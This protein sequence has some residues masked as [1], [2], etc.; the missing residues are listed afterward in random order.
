[1]IACRQPEVHSSYQN[2]S[3]IMDDSGSSLRTF[4][5]KLMF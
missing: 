2:V 3:S 4:S 5:T 1:M